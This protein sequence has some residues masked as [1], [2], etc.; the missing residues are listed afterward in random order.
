M[1]DTTVQ[2]T[3]ERSMKAEE[4]NSRYFQ[5]GASISQQPWRY[6]SPSL[7]LSFP[8]LSLP[9]LPLSHQLPFLPILPS[10]RSR[11]LRSWGNNGVRGSLGQSAEIELSAF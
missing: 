9:S 1:S 5:P 6:P 2:T 8:P 3:G 7:P 11:P 10:L 4:H